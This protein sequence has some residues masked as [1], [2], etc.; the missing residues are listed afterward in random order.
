MAAS[1]P[2]FLSL[3]SALIIACFMLL[4]VR[5]PLPIGFLLSIESFIIPSIEAFEIKSK[6]GVLPLI[7]QPKAMKPSYFLMFFAIVTGISK[8]PGTSINFTDPDKGFFAY[9]RLYGPLE[10]YY[11]KSWKM[12]DVKR[13]NN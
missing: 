13:L 1:P 7:T 6:W 12:P 2:L 9:L 3:G 11:D 8:T 10:S 4:Q 5:I